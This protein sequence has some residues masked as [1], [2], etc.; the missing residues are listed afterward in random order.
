[1]CVYGIYLGISLDNSSN[2]IVL[3]YASA[4]GHVWFTHGRVPFHYKTLLYISLELTFA[5]GLVT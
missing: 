1:M 2:H 3:H 4:L 5:V